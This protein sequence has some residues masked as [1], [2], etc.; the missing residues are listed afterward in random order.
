MMIIASLR[1]EANMPHYFDQKVKTTTLSGKQSV[2]VGTTHT[3]TH[4]LTPI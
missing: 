4:T 1:Y 3:Y 2:R